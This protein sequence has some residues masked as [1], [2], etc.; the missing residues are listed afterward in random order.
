MPLT[1]RIVV[2]P[3]CG[4]PARRERGSLRRHQVVIDGRLQADLGGA[5]QRHHRAGGSAKIDRD[6][7]PRPPG[8]ERLNAARATLPRP[9]GSGLEH[10]I[11]QVW[12][13]AW[14]RR[15][16]PGSARNGEQPSTSSSAQN[17][18]AFPLALEGIHQD[19]SRPIHVG[20]GR[21]VGEQR[22]EGRVEMGLFLIGLR[23]LG[24]PCPRQRLGVA[25]AQLMASHQFRVS[26]ALPPQA[27]RERARDPEIAKLWAAVGQPPLPIQVSHYRPPPR[28]VASGR[29]VA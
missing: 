22:L 2:V 13:I 12:P 29:C 10:Q 28:G 25:V 1:R 27:P 23:R 8:F 24:R 20:E 7:A 5:G 26:R 3:N 21:R 6:D 17:T 15:T 9:P 14:T 16:R 11:S 19:L 4:T 18:T